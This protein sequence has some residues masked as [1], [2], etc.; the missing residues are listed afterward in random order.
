MEEQSPEVSLEEHRVTVSHKSQATLTAPRGFLWCRQSKGSVRRE[1]TREA[2]RR[3]HSHTASCPTAP[4]LG[5]PK[6]KPK[7]E[8]QRGPQSATV[9]Q[10]GQ[11]K[12]DLRLCA[13]L[14][15]Y[16]LTPHVYPIPV[17]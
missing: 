3:G 12:Q 1:R 15:F 4:K 8:I 5:R 11:A 2:N 14:L 16:D 17:T 13:A 6:P 9:T 7:A 10:C